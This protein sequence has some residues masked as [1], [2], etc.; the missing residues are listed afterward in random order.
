MHFSLRI[1]PFG[2]TKTAIV[3]L[4][5]AGLLLI[6][7][8]MGEI[9]GITFR[10]YSPRYAANIATITWLLALFFMTYLDG[11]YGKVVRSSIRPYAIFLGILVWIFSIILFSILLHLSN[12][13]WLQ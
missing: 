3:I 11:E 12:T 7:K 9:P 5:L 6:W 4:G 13:V 8:N 2:W 1:A 10:G